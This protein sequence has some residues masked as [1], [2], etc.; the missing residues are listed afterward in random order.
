MR[1]YPTVHKK[2][3]EVLS[4]WGPYSKKWAGISHIAER[5]QGTLMEFSVFPSQYRGM[6]QLPVEIYQG[7]YIPWDAETDQSRYKYRFELEWKDQVYT[8]VTYV[9]LDDGSIA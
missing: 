3:D 5:D 9:R 6:T 1:S 4:V 7:N 2:R 8:D